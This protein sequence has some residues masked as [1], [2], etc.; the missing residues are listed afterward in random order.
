MKLA[1]FDLGRLY[2]DWDMILHGREC[3][4]SDSVDAIIDSVEHNVVHPPF[5]AIDSDEERVVRAETFQ[6]DFG[7]SDE[8]PF[9]ADEDVDG[10]SQVYKYCYLL[11]EADDE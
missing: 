11:P 3:L 8:F 2:T 6:N 5:S 7:T 4:L 10:C 9:Y 1:K